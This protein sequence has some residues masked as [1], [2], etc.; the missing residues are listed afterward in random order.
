M[1]GPFRSI[2]VVLTSVLL[3]S[4]A[5]AAHA[6][7]PAK[8]YAVAIRDMPLMTG[9]TAVYYQ[10]GEVAQ[11]D[12]MEVLRHRWDWSVVR[13]DITPLEGYVA[14]IDTK[15]G[16]QPDQIVT[17]S[18]IKIRAPHAAGW[19]ESFVAPITVDAGTA[20]TVLE[21]FEERGQT[22]L[23]VIAPDTMGAWVP[24]TALRPATDAEI[25]AYVAAVAEPG[26]PIDVTEPAD[27]EVDD[28]PPALAET[29]AGAPTEAEVETPQEQPATID[30]HPPVISVELR[31]LAR[32]LLKEDIRTA[33]FQPLIAEFRQAEDAEETTA[34]Q[35]E[36]LVRWRS[37]LE[38]RLE[39]QRSLQAID[40]T[41]SDVEDELREVDTPADRL[42]DAK[43]YTITGRFMTS[44][45]YDGQRLP[46]LYRL[47]TVRD[48][49]RRTI[50]YIE[51][52]EMEGLAA[53]IGKIVGLVGEVRE[54]VTLGISVITPVRV[55]V[56]DEGE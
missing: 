47:Q 9:T 16:E 42:A 23:R 51:P 32:M 14:A 3:A 24:D 40:E 49:S 26:E 28:T 27:V 19:A 31:N 48:A 53:Y 50:V 22:Y 36:S 17:I 30:E 8:E 2:Q 33:E 21:S 43:L 10:V 13:S 15:P 5:T 12:V 46:L 34:G 39:V 35:K 56:I 18:R 54:S 52:G 37:I 38:L 11:G 41:L 25:A 55:D 29:P 6:Q 1:I 7:Q 4:L 45:V 20:L 44:T